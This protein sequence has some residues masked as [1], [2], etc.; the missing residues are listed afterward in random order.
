MT[1]K[2]KL[3]LAHWVAAESKKAGADEAAVTIA[4]SRGVS[5][6]CQDHQIDEL[7]ETTQ[8]SLGRSHSRRWR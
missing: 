8:N 7:K 1:N 5:V 6:K 2:E 4:F 3:D